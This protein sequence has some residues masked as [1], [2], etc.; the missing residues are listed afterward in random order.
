[1]GCAGGQRRGNEGYAIIS[2]TARRRRRTRPQRTVQLTGG[3]AA[4]LQKLFH[5]VC[6]KHPVAGW[7]GRPGG[8]GFLRVMM[9]DACSR[10]T[11]AVSRT[12]QAGGVARQV[13]RRDSRPARELP[14]PR[15]APLRRGLLMHMEIQA[16]RNTDRLA[17]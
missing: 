5:H 6:A 17:K 4:S 13:G 9:M 8:E 2:S 11:R 14:D 12:Q 7:L 3:G 15:V 10:K 16:S 1:M